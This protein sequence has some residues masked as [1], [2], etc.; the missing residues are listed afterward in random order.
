MNKVINKH[1]K[2]GKRTPLVENLLL[3]EGITRAGKFLL[4]NILHGFRGVEPAQL[5]GL[6]ENIPFLERLGLMDK[7][8]AQE[9]LRCEID[10]HCY[11][12]LIG[13]NLNHRLSDKSSIYHVPGYEKYLRRCKEPDGDWAVQKFH[14]ENLYSSFIIHELMPN[15]SIYFDTFPKLKVISIQ[16]SPVYLVYSWYKRGFGKRFDGDP[17]LFSLLLQEKGRNIPLYAAGW[18]K[19]YLKLSGMDRCIAMIEWIILASKKSYDRL[20]LLVRKKILLVSYEGILTRTDM[21]LGKINKFL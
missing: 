1:I 5:C 3:I 16:R 7:K 21:V 9:I 2:I 17:K 12:M 11:E 13:R 6:L 18:G 8:V 19:Q 14:K 20:D 15:I 10:T 4:A